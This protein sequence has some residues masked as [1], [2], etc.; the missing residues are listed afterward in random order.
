MPGG[1]PMS[2]LAL[3][4]VVEKAWRR[5]FA[6]WKSYAIKLTGNPKDAEEVVQD[7]VVRTLRAGPDLST[8]LDA[9]RYIL[10]AVKTSALQL[11]RGRNRRFPL[12]ELHPIRRSTVESSPLRMV[13]QRE[14]S[15]HHREL[16][17]AVIERLDILRPEQR[18]AVELLVLREPPLKLREVAE[19]QD[20]AIS[21]VH[22]RLQ[23]AL[24]QLGDAVGGLA[25]RL[26]VR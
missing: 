18:Q 25:E 14:S 19:I 11:L 1:S 12:D 16:Y 13:L 7:A 23:S 26:D 21:T 3:T 5:R 8:E 10:T 9:H 20:A 6:N 24:E 22:S 17:E 4:D 2:E 15:R